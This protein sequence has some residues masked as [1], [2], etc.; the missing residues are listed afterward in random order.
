MINFKPLLLPLMA[1][2]LI[3]CSAS[4]TD[5]QNADHTQ[6]AAMGAAAMA[7]PDNAPVEGAK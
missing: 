5:A 2:L 1:G 4:E 3:S 6:P 7:A